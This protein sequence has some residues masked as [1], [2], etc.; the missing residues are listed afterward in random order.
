MINVEAIAKKIQ[1]LN[2]D[3]ETHY[4]EIHISGD[5]I[6]YI[7]TCSDPLKGDMTDSLSTEHELLEWLDLEVKES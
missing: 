4:V 1:A 7:V 2:T 3:T 6:E 5:C